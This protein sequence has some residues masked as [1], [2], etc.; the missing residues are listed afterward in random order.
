[1]SKGK[2]LSLYIL[3][4]TE[5]VRHL[6]VLLHQELQSVAVAAYVEEGERVP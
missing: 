6:K 3:V 2:W 4:E 1:M 5:K